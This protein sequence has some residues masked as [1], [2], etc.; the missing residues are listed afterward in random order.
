MDIVQ[1]MQIYYGKR[2]PLYDD[3]MGYHQRDTLRALTPL[4]ENIKGCLRGRSVLEIACG[5]CFWTQ[6]VSPVVRSVVATDYNDATLAQAREKA[7]DWD[8]VSLLQADAYQLERVSGRFDAAFAVDWFAH[9]PRS[10]FTEFLDGLHGRLQ[11][12][13]VVLFCDQLPGPESWSGIF[14][15]EGNHLQ[16]RELPDGSSYRVIKHFLAER[17]LREL[18]SGYSDDIRI[19]RYPDCRR[20]VVSYRLGQGAA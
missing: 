10:R 5:P 19:A 9:V 7:L 13:S 14:D 1:E 12:G 15:Q 11:P 6:Q 16:T 8:R 2:A 4:I 3:S 17:E 20:V 18:F